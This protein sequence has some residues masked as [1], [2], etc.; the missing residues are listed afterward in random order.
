MK[1][2]RCEESFLHNPGSA[3]EGRFEHFTM[4]CVIV[5]TVILARMQG[6]PSGLDPA[7]LYCERVSFAK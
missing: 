4:P 3:V 2:A 1:Y 6:S 5:N 7:K